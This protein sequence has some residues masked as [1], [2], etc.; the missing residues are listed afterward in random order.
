MEEATLARIAYAT[1]RGQIWDFV[2]KFP[3][4]LREW[5]MDGHPVTDGLTQAQINAALGMAPPKEK[6]RP[7]RI[8]EK[9]GGAKV[10]TTEAPKPKVPRHRPVRPDVPTVCIVCG[11]TFM[12]PYILHNKKRCENCIERGI[13]P[14]QKTV[15]V[16]GEVQKRKTRGPNKTHNYI[17]YTCVDCGV[18]AKTSAMG[19]PR[20]RCE[21]CLKAKKALDKRVARMEARQAKEKARQE[22]I[23]A[24]RQERAAANQPFVLEEYIYTPNY[25]IQKCERCNCDF[26]KNTLARMQI[27]CKE[28]RQEVGKAGWRRGDRTIVRPC[29]PLLEF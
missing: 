7:L 20:L 15:V 9:K 14:D 18:S 24:K 12:R 17:I 10:A 25:V 1:N 2:R 6:P 26:K 16:N 21:P 29:S 3:S 28:C 13:R 19:M 22:A 4:S 27:I 23:E 5:G 11:E 8:E